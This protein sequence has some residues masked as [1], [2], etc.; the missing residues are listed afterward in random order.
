V[1]GFLLLAPA[2]PA[3]AA[4]RTDPTFELHLEYFRPSFDTRVRFDS[5]DFGNG[6]TLDLERELGLDDTGDAVRGEIL[7]R[8]SERFRVSL[9][10][11]SFDRNGA[12]VIDQPI[13]YGGYV[14]RAG[15]RVASSVR[16]EFAA[17]GVGFAFVRNE[18]VEAGVSLSAAWTRIEASLTGRASIPPLPPLEVTET[19][20]A[21]GAAPMA[22]LWASGWL[23][24][25][26]RLSGNV[27]YLKLEHFQD[28]H[29]D[30]LD[31]G[32]RLEWFVID[33]VGLALGWGG[34][35]INAETD[36]ARDLSRADY[37]YRGARAGVT[38]TF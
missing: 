26:V 10:Y 9:D 6:S 24:G 23:G 12:A 28:W 22:G 4:D 17:L 32:V 36:A 16:S 38:F 14:Y 1:A 5:A 20:S 7:L 13:H 11:A 21:E 30:A 34:T 37:S 18:T 35:E 25:H 27:R 8:A 31:Y 29:G 33:H 19:A 2:T 15:G 3:R